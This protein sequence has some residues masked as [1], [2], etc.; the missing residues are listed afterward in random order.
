MMQS[1]VKGGTAAR[2]VRVDGEFL[3][4]CAGKTGTTS[5][6]TDAWFCGFTPDITAVVWVGYDRPFLSLGKHQAG[7]VVAAPIWTKYMKHVY[8]SMKDPV[9]PEKPENVWTCGICSYTG[10][11]PSEQC[12]EIA[13][14]VMLKDGG[15]K[16]V[17]NGVHYKMKSILDVYIEKEGINKENIFQNEE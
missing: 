3:K 5:N 6:W 10:K 8:N 17:C 1:V 7:A 2:A 4:E 15:P 9:F 13:G 12:T 11:L 16:E 14:E